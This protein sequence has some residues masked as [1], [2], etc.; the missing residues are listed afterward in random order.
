MAVL[1]IA[2]VGGGSGGH[3]FPAVSIAEELLRREPNCC[4]L[5]L[6]SRRP[7]DATVL[8]SSSL[9]ESRVSIQPY[10]DLWSR[11]SWLQFAKKMPGMWNSLREARRSLKTF[12]PDLVIG[13]GAMASVPGIIAAHKLDLPIVLLEQNCLPGRATRLLARRARLTIFGLPIA[14][15][16]TYNWP[17]EFVTCGTPVRGS[18]RDLASR[19]SADHCPKRQ[20]LILGGSQGARSV[21]QIV[22]AALCSELRIPPD[23]TVVHQSGRDDRA[24]VQSEY[25]RCRIPVRVESFLDDM[26]DELATAALVISRAGAVTLQE[27]ACAGVPSLLIPLSTAADS[28]Q[29]RNAS[30]FQQAGAS[31]LIDERQSDSEVACRKAIDQIVNNNDLRLQLA[32]N[33][34][35]FATPQAAAK[36]VDV[37]NQISLSH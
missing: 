35:K 6:T 14:E 23:W 26:S 24:F 34:R 1:R 36:I 5:F 18:I 21:N 27:L 2:F 30:L 17:T 16:V 33:I 32:G 13:L 7:I 10:A 37:L 29:S 15:E 3:L 19:D 8:A 22:A 31:I 20:I 4:F 12:Q 25:D 9:P 11:Q 28:H